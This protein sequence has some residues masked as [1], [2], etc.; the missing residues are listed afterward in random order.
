MSK[1]S[2]INLETKT[3]KSGA[4]YYAADF[5][6]E[7]EEGTEIKATSF[8]LVGKKVGDIVEGEIIA[9]GQYN[10]FKLLK[11]FVAKGGAGASAGIKIAQER[12][13]EM[14]TKTM[15]RKELSILLAGSMRDATLITIAEL[16]KMP[17]PTDEEFKTNW[18][19]WRNW[20]MKQG[21]IGET[22]P[23]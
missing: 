11:P 15:D 6:E 14:I 2:I 5:R 18:L 23:F 22:T 21:E 16:A 19:K 1:Y 20:L 17:F 9:N 8:D 13:Q 3:G 7:S 10:N 12:K 4:S